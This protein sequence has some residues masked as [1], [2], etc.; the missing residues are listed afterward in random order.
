MLDLL[1]GILLIGILITVHEFGHFIVAK[2]AGVKVEVFSI[3][4]GS[5]IVKAQ[6]GETEYRLAWLP[7]GGYV[8]LLGM[9]PAD[10]AEPQDVGRS[11]YDKRPITRMLIYAAGPAMN[12]LLPLAI[13]APFVWFSS[14]YDEVVGNRIGALDY[15]MPAYAAGLREGDRIV[16]L[17]GEPIAAFW[18]I[19]A[20][21]D[22]YAPEQGPIR[23][24]VER[25]GEGRKSFDVKP[26]AEQYTNPLLGFTGTDYKIGYM[27]AA[28]ASDVA[29]A[30]PQGP[31]ARAGLRTFDRVVAVSGE[32]TPS[33]VD[34]IERLRALG[35]GETAKLT[36]ERD[37]P[38][39]PGADGAS[40]TARFPF[41]QRIETVIAHYTA[42]AAGADPGLMPAS[43]C[44]RTIDPAH[45]AASALEVGDCLLAVDGQRQSLGAFLMRRLSHAPEAP[46]T[47]VVLRDGVERE[48]ELRQVQVTLSDPLAGEFEQWRLGFTIPFE[49]GLVPAEQV[50]NDDRLAHGW[51]EARDRLAR[52]FELTLRTIGG[53]FT[54]KVDASQ[55][56]GPLTIFYLASEQARRGLEHYLDLMV[57]LSLSI[58]LFNLLPV[59]LLDGGHILVAGVEMITRRPPSERTRMALQYVGLALILALFA[60]ALFNDA[61]RM[62]R[63]SNG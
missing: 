28:L 16:S 34:V 44:V 12:I 5:P 21:I 39:P 9:D 7:V 56:S 46:K 13:V 54:A 33:Y 15:S 53:L 43:T 38:L 40:I 2:L 1:A 6:W 50:P 23:V 49:R 47:V 11:L 24:E 31:A 42:P 35:A 37:V 51:Y 25:P 29:I 48:V 18:Q 14:Q 30:D 26:K 41:L 10:V 58:G 36:V 27:P 8:R 32:P 61:V 22:D 59:P 60:F 57:L 55:L 17:D 52:E 20:R 3:G 19:S 63:V 62:W 45:P 4:F